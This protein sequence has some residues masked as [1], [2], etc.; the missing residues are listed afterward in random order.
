[1]TTP[2]RAVAP[3]FMP[4]NRAF[5]QADGLPQPGQIFA[6][7]LKAQLSLEEKFLKELGNPLLL[8]AEDGTR[9]G[10]PGMASCGSRWFTQMLDITTLARGCLS[11]ADQQI[12]AH[13][14]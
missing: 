1:M 4:V 10:R 9:Q 14:L 8:Q 3:R 5:T 7:K 2:I 13:K 11:V 6:L 12:C